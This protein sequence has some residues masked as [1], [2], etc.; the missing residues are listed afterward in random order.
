MALWTI[1]SRLAFAVLAGDSQI[2]NVV[3]PVDLSV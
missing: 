1:A 2:R 3:H